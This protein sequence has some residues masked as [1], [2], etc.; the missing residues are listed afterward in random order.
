MSS[1]RISGP[2]L[3][4]VGSIRASDLSRA[5]VLIIDAMAYMPLNEREAT[6]FFPLVGACYERAA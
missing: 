2:P 4:S 1:L 6:T 3:A 5:K